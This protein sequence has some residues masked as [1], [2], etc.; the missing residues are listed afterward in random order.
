MSML[1]LPGMFFPCL[2]LRR[3]KM[4]VF[5]EYYRFKPLSADEN[6][7]VS[8]QDSEI[9]AAI[10]KLN[11]ALTKKEQLTTA[12]NGS[13]RGYSG[14]RDSGVIINSS[15]EAES[16]KIDVAQKQLSDFQNT[17]DSATSKVKTLLAGEGREIKGVET[18][19]NRIIRMIPGLREANRLKRNVDLLSGGSVMGVL[20]I[21]LLAYSLYQQINRIIEEQQRQ[22]EEYKRE[23][24]RAQNLTSQSQYQTWQ[25]QQETA[26]ANYRNR[27]VI[28]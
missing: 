22:K 23:I 10:Q 15:V 7:S 28:K 1:M 16:A 5:S 20:G 11:A 3:R 2:F 24:M 26:L 8:I 19:A 21:L 17:T 6:I 27:P 12:V 14:E 25:T 4:L 13:P 18:S 9:D